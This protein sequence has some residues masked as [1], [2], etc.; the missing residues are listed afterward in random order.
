MP[1]QEQNNSVQFVVLFRGVTMSP[2]SESELKT[3]AEKNATVITRFEIFE[4]EDG[5][6]RWYL[7]V[8]TRGAKPKETKEP[9]I[10]MSARKSARSWGDLNNTINWIRKLKIASAE[11]VITLS[12]T[13]PGF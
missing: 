8:Y 13:G 11:V 10:L 7:R 4:T 9:F 3:L 2:I 12:W 6:G 1:S 5:M